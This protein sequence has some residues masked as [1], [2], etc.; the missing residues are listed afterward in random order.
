M[1]ALP[2]EAASPGR[3]KPGRGGDRVQQ[4]VD[5]DSSSMD[6]LIVSSSAL[7]LVLFVV[8]PSWCPGIRCVIDSSL[9]QLV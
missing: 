1:L 4:L 7:N 5:G 6:N 2:V 8:S 3:S 9:H